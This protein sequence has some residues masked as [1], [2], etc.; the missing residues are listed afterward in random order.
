MSTEK[1]TLDNF[2]VKKLD[3]QTNLSDF[4]CSEQDDLGLNEFIHKEALDYQ[5]ESMGVTH[6][7]YLN[8]TIVG[9][10]TVAMGSISV[11]QTKLRLKSYDDKVRYPAMLLGRLGV[12]NKFR[13]RAIGKCMCKW[14]IGLAENLS[15]EVGCRFIV[16]VT[17]SESR[18]K[19]YKDC[20]FQECPT[21]GKKKKEKNG[22]SQRGKEEN[23][24]MYFQ[25]F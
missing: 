9:Y 4:N 17:K 15:K 2:S 25:M 24:M 14:S 18:V 3:A 7:F 1:F 22:D 12:D 5:K 11:K 8:D 23:R 20:G 13:R 19:F 16:L 21:Y 6:L 10:I